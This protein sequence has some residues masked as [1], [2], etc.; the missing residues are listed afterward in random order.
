M[1][2]LAS[3]AQLRASFF[4][5]ALFLVPA[6]AL[7][8][9]LSGQIGGASDSAWFSALEKPATFPPPATF[10]IVWAVLYA[11][12]GV[13]LALVCAAW[14]A[15]FRG[16]AIAAFVVQLL[17][18]LAWSPVFFGA[19]QIAT[20]LAVIIALDVAVI[21]TIILF[22]RVRRLAAWLLAPYLAWILFAT[23][24]NWQFLELNPG[25][26]RVEDSNAVQRIEL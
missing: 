13:A 2:R 26:D 3:P 5:W 4:R 10:G 1:N 11:M 15:R 16:P 12:M 20:G 19:H 25:A 14:G 17:V 22:W 24:L 6:I 7:L 18:N 23:L 21:V 9:F 8:G